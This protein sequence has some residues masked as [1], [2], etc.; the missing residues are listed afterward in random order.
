[1]R[2]QRLLPAL[3][4]SAL[5]ITAGCSRSD[6]SASASIASPAEA[7]KAA[8]AAAE[9]WLALVD[10]GKY[11]ESHDQAAKLFRGAVDRGT[12]EKQAAGVRGPLGALK[13]RKLS[14]ATYTK[15]APG[16]PDGHYVI[17]QF[18]ASFANKGSAV[19]TVTPMLDPDG[20]W[21]VSG[22]FIR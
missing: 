21:R 8:Q 2:A 13:E 18:N 6:P 9:S 16:A 4:V 20:K 11:G 22:Y 3:L 10:A 14:S 17:L 1:M 19:E 7:E 12:W 5:F 15:T